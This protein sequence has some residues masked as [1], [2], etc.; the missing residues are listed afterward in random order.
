MKPVDGI[1]LVHVSKLT[2]VAITRNGEA[3]GEGNSPGRLAGIEK[4][5]IDRVEK[6][7]LD[8]G[9][10]KWCSRVDENRDSEAAE[11]GW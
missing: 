2:Q 9:A 4:G 7:R 1:S 6:K 8:E 10:R 5:F 3:I 11:S